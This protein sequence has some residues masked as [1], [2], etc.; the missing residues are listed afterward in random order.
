MSYKSYSHY[1]ECNYYNRIAV[2]K[3]REDSKYE[4]KVICKKQN[5]DHEIIRWIV[6]LDFDTD[7]HYSVKVNGM[8]I[9]HDF[10]G[11]WKEFI[12]K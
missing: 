2:D 3:L 7:S 4:I 1:E 10:Y 8:L 12:N 5:L 6:D 9:D 11:D